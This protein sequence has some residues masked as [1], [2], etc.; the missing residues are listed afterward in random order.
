MNHIMVSCG[1]ESIHKFFLEL[2]ALQCLFVRGSNKQQRKGTIISNF[3]RGETTKCPWRKSHNA[4]LLL[5]PSKK[6]PSLAFS[7]A[8]KRIY[9][10]TQL[11][12]EL[13]NLF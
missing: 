4:A 8:K 1:F 9:L 2:H 3:I 12:G 5:A 10:D 11:K 7:L 6:G 13:T